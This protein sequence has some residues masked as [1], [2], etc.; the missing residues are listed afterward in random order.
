[1]NKRFQLYVLEA[2]ETVYEGLPPD[3]MSLPPSFDREAYVAILTAEDQPEEPVLVAHADSMEEVRSIEATLT[4]IG[5]RCL[6]VDAG[7]DLKRSLKAIRE[8]WSARRERSA[9]MAQLMQSRAQWKVTP[10]EGGKKKRKKETDE[11]TWARG[12][13]THLPSVD[14]QQFNPY[15]ARA[16]TYL[17]AL[18]LV[19]GFVALIPKTER[20][21]AH[22][23]DRVDPTRT[24]V[25]ENTLPGLTPP[26]AV[27]P[28]PRQSRGDTDA[29]SRGS[30]GA[31]AAPSVPPLALGR[32][33]LAAVPT[34]PSV[35]PPAAGQGAPAGPDLAALGGGGGSLEGVSVT[36]MVA[37]V[38]ARNALL[39]SWLAD[40][41][42]SDP[43]NLL[44]VAEVLAVLALDAPGEG[45]IPGIVSEGADAATAGDMPLAL[46]ASATEG[47][48]DARGEGPV[49]ADAHA[50]MLAAAG[51]DG[52]A[53]SGELEAVNEAPQGPAAAGEGLNGAELPG[54][55]PAADGASDAGAPQAETGEEAL[56]DDGAVGGDS[57]S[58]PPAE[59]ARTT[60]SASLP[61]GASAISQFIAEGVEEL[62]TAGPAV[63][64][65]GYV[66]GTGPVAT[67][68]ASRRERWDEEVAARMQAGA[69]AVPAVGLKALLD[70][71]LPEELAGQA[72]LLGARLDACRE[73]TADAPDGAEG[74][75]D[76]ALL[77]LL[78]AGGVCRSGASGAD[79]AAQV[80]ALSC[81]EAEALVAR[82]VQAR[83]A[84]VAALLHRV[85]ACLE[86]EDAPWSPAARLAIELDVQDTV[87]YLPVVWLRTGSL[88][89]A[90]ERS[91]EAIACDRLP[92]VL[93][94][95]PAQLVAAITPPAP[96]PTQAPGDVSP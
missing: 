61:P 10:G 82:A 43:G 14:V 27:P 65:R 52:G 89:S 16:V 2:P 47:A 78:R 90:C 72:Q 42:E 11:G 76:L 23:R 67:H 87:A 40:D 64:V 36:D 20:G 13:F 83:D 56:G 79:C 18:V 50:A 9:R 39:E 3:C 93:Q 19:V 31:E 4:R 25:A 1:M 86:A 24:A 66:P 41:A 48:P 35:R 6:F 91:L 74:P 22:Q 45:E 59:A 46:P 28:A 57:A 69:T 85:E 88:V 68:V 60:V 49:L 94:A 51:G 96:E 5:T 17:V 63:R 15:V 62:R 53:A 38:E 58:A 70:V 29:P 77:A 81:T 73:D 32:D 55:V 92:E 54:A 75:G 34:D 37:A 33:A 7:S 84:L 71:T 30:N 44:D 21:A 12:E 26:S 95:P 8:G 80:E